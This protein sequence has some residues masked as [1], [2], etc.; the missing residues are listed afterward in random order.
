MHGMLVACRLACGG[1]TLDT[2]W[3]TYFIIDFSLEGETSEIIS[4]SNQVSRK[5]SIGKSYFVTEKP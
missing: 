5:E 1:C 3:L 2:G 4:N